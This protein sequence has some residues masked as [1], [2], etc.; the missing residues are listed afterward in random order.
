MLDTFY[1]TISAADPVTVD[2]DPQKLAAY[3]FVMC[4]I[5]RVIAVH[6]KQTHAGNAKSTCYYQRISNFIRQ[7]VFLD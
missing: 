4:N 3:Q 7:K 2:T 5:D 6:L 1:K